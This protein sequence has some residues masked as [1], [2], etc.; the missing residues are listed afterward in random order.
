MATE[1]TG[2]A[3]QDNE[4][5]LEVGDAIDDTASTAD[6]AELQQD[7]DQTADETEESA[8]DTTPEADTADQPENADGDTEPDGEKPDAKEQTDQFVLKHLDETRTVSRDEA[9]QLAQKG[10]DYDRVR[11]KYDEQSES[12]K[13]LDSLKQ[14]KETVSAKIKFMEEFATKNGYHSMDEMFDV[15]QASQIAEQTGISQEAALKQVHLDRRE[16]ELAAKE[17]KLTQEKTAQTSAADQQKAAEAKRQ[18]DFTEFSKSEY[19]KI[20]ATK[21]PQEVWQTY[22]AGGCTLVQAYMAYEN[23][24]LKTELAAQEK[25]ADNKRR[26]AGSRKT[27]GA[28]QKKDPWEAAWDANP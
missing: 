26:S 5:W 19:G 23:A 22:N 9:V 16:Q 2:T 12:L 3:T 14:Y 20:E 1:T 18:A 24:Q 15:I 11:Q 25:N 21:I 7:D 27:A 28:G 13:E 6:T 8:A 4:N 17:A 10:L